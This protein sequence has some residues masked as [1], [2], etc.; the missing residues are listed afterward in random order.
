MYAFTQQI[1][2]V[3][4]FG[5]PLVKRTTLG[6]QTMLIACE[7]SRKIIILDLHFSQESIVIANIFLF[8]N[9]VLCVTYH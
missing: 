9:H 4:Y 7:S 8:S 2:L 1:L 3:E 5:Q 6:L